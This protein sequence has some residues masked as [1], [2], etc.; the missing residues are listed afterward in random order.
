MNR[1]QLVR[2]SF[3]LLFLLNNPSETEAQGIA[4]VKGSTPTFIIVT[5]PVRIRRPQ[6]TVQLGHNWGINAIPKREYLPVDTSNKHY[7]GGRVD[8]Q[9]RGIP[10]TASMF[11][12]PVEFGPKVIKNPYVK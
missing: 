10:T 1:R 9:Q 7:R 5:P 11:A 3:L 4:G 8:D 6:P 12:E 2:L